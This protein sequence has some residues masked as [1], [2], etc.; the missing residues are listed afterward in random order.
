MR[1]IEEASAISP[2]EGT[3]TYIFFDNVA[4][5]RL[6]VSRLLEVAEPGQDTGIAEDGSL[7]TP[8]ASP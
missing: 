8:T 4:T 2:F 5:S 6:I 7:A 3:G 1:R